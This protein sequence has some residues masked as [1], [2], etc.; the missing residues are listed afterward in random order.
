M[1]DYKWLCVL[2][3]LLPIKGFSI[4]LK[5]R[6]LDSA[7]VYV[8]TNNFEGVIFN[9]SSRYVAFKAVSGLDTVNTWMPTHKEI[10]KIEKKV[11]RLFSDSMKSRT[12][13]PLIYYNRQYLGYYN[14]TGEKVLFIT[15]FLLDDKCEFKKNLNR[16]GNFIFVQFDGGG[17]YFDLKYIVEKGIITNFKSNPIR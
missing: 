4:D 17:S 7:Y 12:V 13:K 2:V 14:E 11:S 3:F 15:F 6:I 16:Y 10:I 9:P 8:K 1:K 5:N